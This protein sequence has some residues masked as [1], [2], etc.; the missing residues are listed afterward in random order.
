MIA[1]VRH[2]TQRRVHFTLRR[3][4]ISRRSRASWRGQINPEMGSVMDVQRR[5]DALLD[6]LSAAYAERDALRI[7]VRELRAE[8]MIAVDAALTVTHK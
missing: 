3:L 2:G 5:D 7:Q 4:A 1:F 6:A 8:L